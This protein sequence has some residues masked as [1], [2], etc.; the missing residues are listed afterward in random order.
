MVLLS[1]TPTATVAFVLTVQYGVGA[2]IT[3]VLTIITT[4]AI[5]PLVV[6]YLNLFEAAGVYAYQL[7]PAGGAVGVTV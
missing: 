1:V 7:V 5:A 2:E 3:T 4:C 6:G